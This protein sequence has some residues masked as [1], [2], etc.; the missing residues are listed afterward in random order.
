MNNKQQIETLRN[1]QAPLELG[2]AQFREF[3]QLPVDQI[4]VFL[5]YLPEHPIMP[6][7]SQKQIRVLQG[8]SALSPYATRN[9]DMQRISAPLLFDH[10]LF[11]DH[12]RFWSYITSSAASIGM[13]AASN[14]L[15]ARRALYLWDISSRDTEPFYG[16]LI[17]NQRV[18]LGPPLGDRVD[19]YVEA[20]I[21]NQ[22]ISCFV[23]QTTALVSGL[24][25]V[26]LFGQGLDS[27][28]TNPALGVKFGLLLLI[29]ALLSFIHFRLQPQIDALFAQAVVPIPSEIASRISQ[30][31][32]RRKR[33][34]SVCTFVVLTVSM[35]GVQVWK[36]FP[37]WLTAGL[38]AG[39]AA[40]TWRAY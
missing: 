15:Q 11:I 23:F 3:D 33:A 40:F 2:P 10:S 13:H 18:R 24:A 36:P 29:S 19:T 37:G 38:V 22:A 1:R 35:L 6:G 26:F 7:E 20:I 5:Q 34:A 30:L 12:P 14:R 16:L 39:I 25:M 31:R 32:L 21:R 27:L 17:V 4:A 8:D 9:E 28:V